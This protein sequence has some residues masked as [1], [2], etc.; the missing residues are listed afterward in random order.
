MGKERNSI[1]QQL[2]VKYDFEKAIQKTDIE[3]Y[4]LMNAEQLKVFSK[5]KLVDIGSHSHSHYNLGNISESLVKDELIRSKKI[6]EET[7]GKEVNTI[8][9]PDGNYGYN[10]KKVSIEAGYKNLIAVKYQCKDDLSDKAILPR[11]TISNTTTFESNMIQIQM[12]FNKVGF[13]THATQV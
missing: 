5:S 8:A 1:I 9:Y 6:I 7:I 13:Y 2:M 3:N 4:K 11:L 12:A 10:V